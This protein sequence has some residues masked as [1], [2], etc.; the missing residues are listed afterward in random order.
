MC[1]I[2]SITVGRVRS[3]NFPNAS[4]TPAAVWGGVSRL[5]GVSVRDGL[6]TGYS[7]NRQLHA[8]SLSV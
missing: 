6:T 1:W 8:F 3:R 4:E 7:R 5:P 2:V